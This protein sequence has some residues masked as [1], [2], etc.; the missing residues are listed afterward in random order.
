MTGVILTSI[1]PNQVHGTEICYKERESHQKRIGH[2]L[3]N[4][5]KRTHLPTIGRIISIILKKVHG[6]ETVVNQYKT[7][8]S[9]DTHHPSGLIQ[10]LIYTGSKTSSHQDSYYALKERYPPANAC[11][12]L[13]AIT[14]PKICLA[15]PISYGTTP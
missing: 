8:L 6:T 12:K 3:P 1:I 5:R 9:G 10:N 13:H 15:I 7:S 2:Q 4:F 14:C 11:S